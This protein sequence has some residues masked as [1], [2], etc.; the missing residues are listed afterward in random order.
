MRRIRDI[1]LIGLI[2][3][4]SLARADISRQ[5]AEAAQPL[6]EGVPEVSVVR[7][8]GLLKQNLGESDWRAVAEKLLEAMV[9]ANQTADAFKLL[10]DLRLRQSPSANFWRAQLLASSHREAEALALYRQIA[11]DRN[12]SLGSDALLGAAEMLRALGRTDE[13]LQIFSELFHDPKWTVRAQLRAAELYL[14][15]SDALAARRLLERVQ[16]TTAFEKKERHFLRGRLE[17]ALRRPDRAIPAFESVLKNPEGVT[18]ETLTAALFALADAHLQLKTPESGDDA[19]ENFIEHRPSDGDLARV[20]AKL[21]EL[22][23]SERKPSRT[24]LDRWTRDPAEPRRAFAQWYLARFDLRLGRRDRAL[25]HF[26]ALQR[27]HPQLPVLA[28]AFL[29]FAQLELEERHFDEALAL[30]NEA[31][32]LRPDPTVLER[33]NLFAAQIQ[34]RAKHFEDAT[35]S[36]EQI[37]NSDSN[38]ASLAMFNAALSWLQK[39]DETRFLADAEEFGKKTKDEKSRA[40]LRLEAGLMEAAKG[41]PR[42]TDSLRNFLR[43]FPEAERGSE[44]WVALAELAFHASP[45]RLDEARKDLARAESKPTQTARERADY[46]MIWLEDTTSGGEAK[47]IA[48]AKKFIQEHES[49]SLVASVRMKLGEMYYRVE[50]FANAETQ[51]ELLAEQNSAGPFFE[52]ALFFAGESAMASMAGQSLD[53][54]IVLFDRVVQLNGELKWAAR[55]EQAVIERKLGKS[56]D[57]LVL[58]DEVLNG[59]ARPAEKREAICGKGDIF[60]EIAATDPQNYL[61]AIEAYDK[62][63]SDKDAPPHWR[64]QALFKKGLCLEK[65]ADRGAALASFYTVLDEGMRPDRPHEF[66]WFYKAGFDAGQL[67]EADAKWESAA[68]V[69]EKLAA[70]GGTRSDEARERLDRLRLEHFLRQE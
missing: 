30:L 57:A 43:E 32:T 25:E 70:A 64:N 21:D 56:Q 3:V 48:L 39:G 50:D 62:L 6:A 52:R 4:A 28:P 45:P 60:F 69:Y 41:D 58:Y 13:A 8:E 7:L 1:G 55:N 18:H 17:V 24:E 37:G 35:V 53:R 46:L 14:D 38:L 22:Y 12:S 66:F 31:R 26:G 11:A 34:Y 40:D 36:F 5:L 59:A 16:P 20:F 19:L 61:R 63:A 15:K 29:E 10:A 67:L 65:K 27:T 23:R 49:S 9:A 33:V 68:A 47:V 42:A 44:A 54:A 51:F 2:A